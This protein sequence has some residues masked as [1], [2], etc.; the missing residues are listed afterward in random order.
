[1]RPVTDSFLNAVRGSHTA[2]FRARLVAP[3]SVGI[4]PSGT[5]INIL[6]G[7]VV[8]DTNASVTSTLDLVTDLEW[9]GTPS[10]P[11][12]PYGQEIYVERGLRYGAG[13]P[14]YVGLGYFR[15][16][17]VKQNR[18]PKGT[19]RI[20]GSDRMA[21]VVD[22]R[23]IQPIQFG[24]GA[25]IGA[26]IDLIVGDVVP[27]L[28]SVYDWDAYSETLKTGYIMTDDR[29]KFLQEILN[30]YG[31]IGYF[32]YA[33]RLQVRDV[34][35]PAK[36]PVWD[37]DSGRD[38]VLIEMSRSVSRDGVYN[39]VV[40]TGE[41]VGD[42]DPVRGVAL[43]EDPASPTYWYG[44]FGKVPRFFSSPFL[45]TNG[46]CG[47]AARSL[48]L[49]S[50]GL[51]YEVILESIPNPALEGWD[52]VR[53]KYGPHDQETHILSRIRYTLSAQGVMEIETRKQYLNS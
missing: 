11:G 50:T 46:Q 8:F 37:I 27:G 7:D 40:A 14:E 3:G 25:S 10:A 39:G 28:V 49:Q 1:M 41:P 36:D 45:T 17:S 47:N 33:G 22:G 15:I 6:S 53:V 12:N 24:A 18:A 34:P 23:P 29:M 35:D 26:V 19:L 2:V 48:L 20:S 30:A 38:G 51:P 21:N 32:D 13:T 4:N 16:D 9:P 5:P 44:T 52:V 43:D 31:K 42:L